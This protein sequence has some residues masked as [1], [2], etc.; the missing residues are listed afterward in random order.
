MRDR[1]K[2]GK[3]SFGKEKEGVI[4]ATPGKDKREIGQVVKRKIAIRLF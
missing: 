4:D 2:K 1:E 3:P